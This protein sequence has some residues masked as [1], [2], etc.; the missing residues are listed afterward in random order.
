MLSIAF[1]CYV[2]LSQGCT[3]R[4][5]KMPLRRIGRR[6]W[7]WAVTV[8]VSLQAAEPG[9]W[10]CFNLGVQSMIEVLYFAM[11]CWA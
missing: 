5:S 11:E 1:H 3:A 4:P 9:G 2:V 10:E 6:C 8:V 7:S